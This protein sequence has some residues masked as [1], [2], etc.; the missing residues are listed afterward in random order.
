VFIAEFLQD[1]AKSAKQI[2]TFMND[3]ADTAESFGDPTQIGFFD[4]GET[5]YTSRDV[6]EGAIAKYEQE[7]GR[8]IGRPDYDFY[9]DGSDV[10]NLGTDSE[11]EN[12]ASAEADANAGGI[13]ENP[14]EA[15]GSGADGG[16]SELAQ[17]MLAG[18]VSDDEYLSLMETEEGRAQLAEAL[19]TDSDTQSVT[20]GLAVYLLYQDQLR[21][22]L[23]QTSQTDESVVDNLL[24]TEPQE[25]AEVQENPAG[26][27]SQPEETNASEGVLNTQEAEESGNPLLDTVVE[28][29]GRRSG[30]NINENADTN[31]RGTLKEKVSEVSTNTLQREEGANYRGDLTYTPHPQEQLILDA[32]AKIGEDP[33]GTVRDLMKPGMWTDAQVKAGKI[34]RDTLYQE[35][36]STGDYSAYDAWRKIT[37]EHSTPVAQ[38]LAAMRADPELTAERLYDNSN[39]FL[40]EIEAGEVAGV[41]GVDAKVVAEARKNVS[42]ISGKIARL[43]LE[44]KSAAK[45]GKTNKQAWEQVKE[46][47]LDLADEINSIRHVGL[48]VDARKNKAIRKGQQ[49]IDAA[50]KENP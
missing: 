11:G 18:E 20:T 17:R 3:L 24:G 27:N 23:N 25:A 9:G 43:E 40:D 28:S 38:S 16:L 7:T 8:T 32:Y 4:T 6:L 50:D 30:P 12:R 49:D 10:F 36:A 34:V 14:G 33:G 37:Q 41:R 5:E 31:Q 45:S 13:A 44:Q 47:Y 46:R 48:I 42:D 15:A 26:V 2:R 29:L 21:Q 1:N 19:G 39:K 22:S 35:A